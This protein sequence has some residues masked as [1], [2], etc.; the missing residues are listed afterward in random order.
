MSE[1]AKVAYCSMEIALNP[2]I[3]TYSGGLGMLAGDTLRSAA[4]LGVPMVGVTLAH[5]KGYFQQRL[6]EKGN[7]TEAE[8]PWNPE[9]LKKHPI[10]V[11][12]VPYAQVMRATI[13]VNA[14]FFNTQRM[15]SQ[16]L[17]NAY[18]SIEIDL[19]A[20]EAESRGS[21]PPG[22]FLERSQ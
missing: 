14:S 11:V 22:S 2:S 7:Q 10:Q 17:R 16:Y 15:L 8:D 12:Y 19:S 4:D 20:A 13:A 21:P 18:Q 3:P 9:A 5:R 6:D 1:R